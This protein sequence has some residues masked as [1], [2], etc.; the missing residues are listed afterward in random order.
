MWDPRRIIWPVFSSDK[1][2]SSFE[3][4]IDLSAGK[5]FSRMIRDVFH[6]LVKLDPKDLVSPTTPKINTLKLKLV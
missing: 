3:V 5:I 1:V 4:K 2:P 6:R